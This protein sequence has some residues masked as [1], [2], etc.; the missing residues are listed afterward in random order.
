MGGGPVR[1]INKIVYGIDLIEEHLLTAAGIPTRPLIAARP[2]KHIAE[3]S[4][5]AKQTGVLLT[6]DYLQVSAAKDTRAGGEAPVTVYA[7]LCIMR[8]CPPQ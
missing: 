2:L 3:Y 8:R 6:K 7:T 5:N 1:D 4:V